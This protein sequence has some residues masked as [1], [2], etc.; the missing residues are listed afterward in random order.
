MKLTNMMSRMLPILALAALLATI[1]TTLPPA[2]DIAAQGKNSPCRK[3]TSI[4]YPGGKGAPHFQGIP[5]AESYEPVT[6]TSGRRDVV[7]DL[8]EVY[9]ASEANCQWEVVSNNQDYL[10]LSQLSGTL[11]A[12]QHDTI[13][14]SINNSARKLPP[15]TYEERVKIRLGPESDRWFAYAKITLEVLDKC[16]IKV[17]DASSLDIAEGAI[18]ATWQATIGR[19]PEPPLQHRVVVWNSSNSQCRLSAETNR[20]FLEAKFQD[21]TTIG[22][23]DTAALILSANER[24]QGEDPGKRQAAITIHDD[25]SGATH[26]LYITLETE[27]PPCQLVVQGTGHLQFDGVAR[28][29]KPHSDRI[30]L[31]NRGG[32]VCQWQATTNQSWLKVT[33]SEGVVWDDSIGDPIAIEVVDTIANSLISTGGDALPH[34]GA[35]TFSYLARGITKTAT[36]PVALRLSKPSCQMSKH[37]PKEMLIRYSPGEALNPARHHLPI[38]ISNAPDSEECQYQTR[39]PNWL[40]TDAGTGALPDGERREVIVKLNANSTEAQAGQEQYDGFITFVLPDA[41]DLEIP[42]RLETECPTGKAC[43]YLHTSHTETQVGDRAEMTYTVSNSSNEPVTAQLTL[44][45]PDGWQI[46]GEGFAQK[47]S[48]ICTAT[49]EVAALDQRHIGMRAYPNHEGEFT[50]KGR[51]EYIRTANGS[52]AP[53][54]GSHE[55]TIIRVMPRDSSGTGAPAPTPPPQPTATPAPTIPP[56]SQSAKSVNVAYTPPTAQPHTTTTAPA[57]IRQLQDRDDRTASIERN[58]RM[59]TFAVAVLGL[60]VVVLLALFTV[61]LFRGRRPHQQVALIPAVENSYSRAA[62]QPR[63][64]PTG[65][66]NRNRRSGDGIHINRG[67]RSPKPHTRR[68]TSP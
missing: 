29:V 62:Y 50:L 21:T 31:Q 58:V 1:A 18:V 32:E 54:P 26:S 46:D 47:C 55:Q 27:H 24:W 63:H 3:H 17:R 36:V 7:R 33:P 2:S 44:E 66:R 20:D 61:F 53:Y 43:G 39:L 28:A 65:R 5:N 15:G 56:V 37:T 68:Q 35:V 13:R 59:L 16:R 30:Q 23:G 41:P 67:Y 8:I 25:I 9:N 60:I 49:Y 4:S 22:K 11:G 10:H 19:T 51:A 12:D 57:N 6:D 64:P 52:Q 40:T 42:V 45:L 14:V 38:E 48:G 34:A